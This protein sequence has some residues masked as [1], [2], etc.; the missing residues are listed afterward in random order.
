M[1]IIILELDELIK[2]IQNVMEDIQFL[3]IIYLTL[4][5]FYWNI[6]NPNF[7]NNLL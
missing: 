6:N 2:Y 4:D 5:L 7:D 1:I 3:K